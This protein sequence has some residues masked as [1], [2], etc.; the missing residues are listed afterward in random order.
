[1]LGSAFGYWVCATDGRVNMPGLVAAVVALGLALGMLDNPSVWQV[2][3]MA[4]VSVLAV[5]LHQSYGLL[6]VPGVGAVM[7]AHVAL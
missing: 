1:M 4:V 7:L 5:G 2:A 6:M 3:V